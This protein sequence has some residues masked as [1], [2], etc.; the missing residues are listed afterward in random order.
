MAGTRV[1]D[2]PFSPGL[3]TSACNAAAM[4][5]AIDSCQV[6]A[7]HI[8][9]SPPEIS[10]IGSFQTGITG[11]RARQNGLPGIK[12]SKCE[13]LGI[14]SL[15]TGITGIRARQNGLPGIRA[16]QSGLPGIK[17]SKC[18]ILGFGVSSNEI[19]GIGASKSVA[20]G[21]WSWADSEVYRWRSAG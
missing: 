20:S 4:V 5:L 14:G 13:I 18:E 6:V 16:R 12:V 3:E 10:G 19:P 21:I 11:I 17:V 9:V 7:E 1:C 2:L 8:R 15:Q